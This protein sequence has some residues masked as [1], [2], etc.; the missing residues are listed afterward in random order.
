MK[1]YNINL[2]KIN[3]IKKTI[4]RNNDDSNTIQISD[5]LV[6]TAVEKLYELKFKLDKS[7]SHNTNKKLST[8]ISAKSFVSTVNSS[9]STSNVQQKVST[10]RLNNIQNRPN[11]ICSE[12]K[13]TTISLCNRTLNSNSAIKENVKNDRGKFFYHNLINKLNLDEKQIF[14]DK[15]KSNDYKRY[16]SLE[17]VEIKPIDFQIKSKHI[18]PINDNEAAKSTKKYLSNDFYNKAIAKSNSYGTAFY[19]MNAYKEGK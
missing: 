14:S 3:L 7:K 6:H 4:C 8:C 1:D 16:N 18:I 12:D 5:D 9:P 17:K 10:E 19:L 15:H 13:F 11:I 2:H